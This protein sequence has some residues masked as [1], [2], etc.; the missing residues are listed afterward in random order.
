MDVLTSLTARPIAPLLVLLFGAVAAGDQPQVIAAAK[1]KGGLIEVREQQN[2]RHL[3][4]NGVVQA[5]VS[6]KRPSTR[7]DLLVDLLVGARRRARSVLLIGLG[8]GNTAMAFRSLGVRV[9]AVE[10]EPKVI[11]FARSYFHYQ[12]DAVCQDGLDYLKQAKAQFDLIVNDSFSGEQTVRPLMRQEAFSLMLRRLT[13]FGVIAIRLNAS[14][15][16]RLVKE[17]LAEIGSANRKAGIG[18]APMQLLTFTSGIADEVQNLYLLLSAGV[19]EY[20]SARLKAVPLFPIRLGQPGKDAAQEDDEFPLEDS[21]LVEDGRA[22]M[23]RGLVAGYLAIAPDGHLFLSVPPVGMGD[24]HVV[25]SGPLTASLRSVLRPLRHR[26]RAMRSSVIE[27]PTNEITDLIGVSAVVGARWTSTRVAAAVEGEIK[28]LARRE[29]VVKG[30]PKTGLRLVDSTTTLGGSLYTLTISKIHWAVTEEEWKRFRADKLD[31]LEQRL[32]AARVS[33]RKK[34][35]K[36]ILETLL[37][38]LRE[39]FGVAAE[40]LVPFHEARR[41]LDVLN[42]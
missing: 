19:L 17:L 13:R 35:K 6:T 16:S 7:Q 28:L 22:A 1:G 37:A 29:G 36:A 5:V 2:Q 10:L 41:E 26:Q 25:L 12:G 34:E 8:S 42:P 21:N 33:G 23:R 15:R 27:S 14:P 40:Q 20:Y 24:L 30:M 3:L 11:E 32:K 38:R 31:P 39:R 4:I 9:T 18:A